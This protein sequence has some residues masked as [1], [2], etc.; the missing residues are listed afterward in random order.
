MNAI[1]MNMTFIIAAYAVMWG[2]VLGYLTRLVIKGSRARASYDRM[3]R[4]STGDIG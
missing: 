1:E 3:R 4:D 2:V